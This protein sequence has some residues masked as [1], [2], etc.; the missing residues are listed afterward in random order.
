[1]LAFAGDHFGDVPLVEH[2][3][4]D[5]LDVVVA[6]AEEATPA[7]ATD[8]ERFN[9]QGVQRFARGEALAEL[10]GWSPQL[11]MCHALALGLKRIDRIDLRLEP[12]EDARIGRAKQGG[13]AAFKPAKNAVEEASDNFPNTFQNFHRLLYTLE[14]AWAV[15][16]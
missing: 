12:T 6:H 3:A 7:F 15:R 13:D 11:F 16:Q 4:A 14:M 8:S 9:Q 1:G 2:H 10:S 5:Q